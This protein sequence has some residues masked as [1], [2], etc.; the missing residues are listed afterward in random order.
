[1]S[2]SEKSPLET[3]AVK[4][5]I[6]IIPI[7]W[8]VID[9]IESCH[10]YEISGFID[11]NAIKN[12]GSFPVLG[13]DEDWREIQEKIP[14]IRVAVVIDPPARRE[15]LFQHY[16]LEAI[17]TLISPH[18]HISP[19]ACVGLGS[20]IQRDAIL[21]PHVTVGMGC[22]INIRAVL[23]HETH[24]ADFC[25]IGPGASILGAVHIQRH[26]YIGA[27]AIIRQNIHIGEGAIIGAG[28]VVV[29]DVAAGQTVT[30]VPA[31]P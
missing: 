6:A 15:T 14:G 11:R 20:L 17:E 26:A 18:A 28:A 5:P 10:C 30:G 25:T 8:D 12:P 4:T 13:K 3:I 19:Y 7:E 29:K 23:H 27:G 21:M 31:R 9:L 22:N 2:P 16:G 24:V 1:V